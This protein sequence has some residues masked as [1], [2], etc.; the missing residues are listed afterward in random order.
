MQVWYKDGKLQHDTLPDPVEKAI[1]ETG[2][3]IIIHA[4]LRIEEYDKYCEDLLRIL[5]FLH[6]KEVITHPSMY[7]LPV[8]KDTIYKLAEC[9]KKMT[10]YFYDNGIIVYIE[11]N[12]RLD[13]FNYSPEEMK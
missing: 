4:L 13:P 3:P 5:K 6:H 2:F 12:G 10:D 11:N 7:P 8:E 1:L 9:N